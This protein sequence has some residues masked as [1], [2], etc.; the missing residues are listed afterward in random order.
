MHNSKHNGNSHG[1]G[2][3]MKLFH[4]PDLFEN[5]RNRKMPFLL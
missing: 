4:P 2:S 5:R 3:G 1:S